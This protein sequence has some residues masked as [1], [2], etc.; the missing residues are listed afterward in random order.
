M[1]EL[2]P[3]HSYRANQSQKASHGN[4]STFGFCSFLKE[5]NKIKICTPFFSFCFSDFF[6]DA[7]REKRPHVF[8]QPFLFFFFFFFSTV[9]CHHHFLGLV[10]LLPRG[11]NHPIEAQPERW[12]AVIQ[13]LAEQ[14]SLK[15][16]TVPN[17][18]WGWSEYLRLPSY[19]PR[20]FFPKFFF[21]LENLCLASTCN[22]E[23][24][25]FS[26]V[27]NLAALD[28]LFPKKNHK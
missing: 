28:K 11:D 7:S 22:E 8:S 5:M 10:L 3:K 9:Q 24:V 26:I 18:S 17:I 6:L 23:E 4:N 2:V 21:L 27:S 12:V 14:T 16:S 13:A 15:G 1:H 20:H 19:C 25:K